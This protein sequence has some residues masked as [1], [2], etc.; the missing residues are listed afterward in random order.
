MS[1][2]YVLGVS[3]GKDS[4]RQAEFCRQVLGIEPVLVSVGLP[5][6][7]TSETGVLNIQNLYDRNY[8]VLMAYPATE[9]LKRLTRYCFFTLGNLKVASEVALFNG[10]ARMADFASADVILWG[11]NPA[12]SVGDT[13][14]AGRSYFDGAS[15]YQI[16]TLS[17]CKQLPKETVALHDFFYDIEDGL[18]KIAPKIVFMGGIIP[19]W[20]NLSNGLFSLLSGFGARNETEADYLNIS[21]VDEDFV[22]IN[23]YIKYLKFGFGRTT[24]ILNEMIRNNTISRKY[25]LELLPKHEPYIPISEIR[26]FAKFIG[27]DEH[28]VWVEILKNTNNDLFF[29]QDS[30][31][32]AKPLLAQAR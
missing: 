1:L 17:Q 26:R 16:N 4:L 29:T 2:R 8:E 15:I 24:D 23:Q 22:L 12:Y 19:R 28:S 20:S 10:A 11:E 13:A 3:G 27:V 6:S 9:T 5:P 14:S 18:R 32:V 7:Q 31:P 30:R 25:A 21:A